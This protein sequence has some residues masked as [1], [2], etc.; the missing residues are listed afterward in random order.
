MVGNGGFSVLVFCCHQANLVQ[1]VVTAFRF[2]SF[3]YRW[4]FSRDFEV[5]YIKPF[6][7]LLTRRMIDI[8]YFEFKNSSF[9]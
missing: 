2:F 3:S 7:I 8:T 6:P 1:R 4:Q 5:S 9:L